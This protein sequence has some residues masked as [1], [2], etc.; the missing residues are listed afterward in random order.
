MTIIAKAMK[1][2]KLN[3]QSTDAMLRPYNDA[4]AASNWAI[5]SI[6][7]CLQA[8]IIMGRTSAELAPKDYMTRAEVAAIVERLLQSSDLI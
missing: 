4:L 1:I 6:A 8:G 7:D 2:T 3:I 5:T